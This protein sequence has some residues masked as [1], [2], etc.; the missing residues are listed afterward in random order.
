MGVAQMNRM[1]LA[2]ERNESI[3]MGAMAT[4]LGALIIDLAYYVVVLFP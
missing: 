1:M 3:Q 4:L 2:L